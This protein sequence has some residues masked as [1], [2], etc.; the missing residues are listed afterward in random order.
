MAATIS[1]SSYDNELITLPLLCI[2]QL[3]VSTR[4]LISLLYEQ[5]PLG[6][7]PLVGPDRSKRSR[8]Q[9]S[10]RG[11]RKSVARTQYTTLLV[12][13]DRHIEKQI[14]NGTATSTPA[15]AV[16]KKRAFEKFKVWREKGI[17][18]HYGTPPLILSGGTKSSSMAYPAKRFTYRKFRISISSSSEILVAKRN[19]DS[20]KEKTRAVGRH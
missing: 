14:R 15:Q 4:F 2:K 20:Q 16:A 19:T 3:Y 13:T 11:K 17:M 10:K 7:T 12:A 1:F 6:Q 8:K 5:L 9:P 18:R